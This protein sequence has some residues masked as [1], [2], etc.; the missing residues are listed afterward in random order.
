MAASNSSETTATMLPNCDKIT[1]HRKANA[2]AIGKIVIP[3]RSFQVPPDATNYPWPS[4]RSSE[5][6]ACS[7]QFLTETQQRSGDQYLYARHTPD[8]T[9]RTTLRARVKEIRQNRDD[10]IGLLYDYGDFLFDRWRG[11]SEEQRKKIIDRTTG[12]DSN[13]FSDDELP[14]IGLYSNGKGWPNMRSQNVRLKVPFL[15]YATALDKMVL[16][17]FARVRAD[18][19]ISDFSMDDLRATHSTAYSGIKS[20]AYNPNLVSLTTRRYGELIPFQTAAAHSS[21][22]IGVPRA[23]HLIDTQ[24]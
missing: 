19:P 12:G 10:L 21:T 9:L 23:L 24:S 16:L 22:A 2:K 18:H 1:I 13:P 15:S 5:C 20:W 6:P 8:E 11:S 4:T 14:Q 7:Y 17:N 3:M